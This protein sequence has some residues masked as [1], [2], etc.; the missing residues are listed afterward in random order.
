MNL[1]QLVNMVVNTVMRRLVNLGVN[2][3]IDL[4]TRMG[5]SDDEVTDDD[6]AQQAGA[7][8]TAKRARQAAKVTRRLGRF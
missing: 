7:K 2:K 4:A 1:N 8:E 3:G 6:R 5:K